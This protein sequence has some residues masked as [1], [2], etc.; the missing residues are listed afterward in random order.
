MSQLQVTVDCSSMLI[1]TQF[2]RFNKTIEHFYY[3]LLFT[4]EEY[5]NAGAS[6]WD[7]WAAQGFHIALRA[8]PPASKESDQLTVDARPGRN[9]EVT[10]TSGNRRALTRLSELLQEIEKAR[11][12]LPSGGEEARLQAMLDNAAIEGRLLGPIRESPKRNPFSKERADSIWSMVKQ[13][14]S[15][16][17]NWQIQSV[18]VAVH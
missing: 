11:T 5:A 13:G 14:L 4:S 6:A 18:R 10:A 7:S 12:S 9:F 15:A 17:I 2:F 3:A 16:L 8:A 1:S